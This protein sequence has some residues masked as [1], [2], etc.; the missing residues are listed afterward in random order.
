M[1]QFPQAGQFCQ[2]PNMQGS[3]FMPPNAFMNPMMMNQ[4]PNNMTMNMGINNNMGF[5]NFNNMNNMNMNMNNMN[6]M[7]MNNMNNI[8]NVNNMNMNNMN[9]AM[10]MNN[11][12]FMNGNNMNFIPNNNFGMNNNVNM[13]MNNNFNNNFDNNNQ[14]NNMNQANDMNNQNVQNQQEEAMKLIKKQEAEARKKLF[15]DIINKESGENLGKIET[16][17]NMANMGAITRHYI[18]V[19]SAQ[20]PNKYIPINDALKSSDQDYLILGILGE[21]LTKQ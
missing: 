20:N 11:M 13:N 9:A 3:Q 5:N 4:F 7:N 2:F 21:Y 10:M 12:M 6:N 1:N 19:D 14:V 18:E 8:N 15:A 17:S 16:I